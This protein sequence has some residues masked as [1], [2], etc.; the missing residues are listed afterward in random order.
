MKHIKTF[1]KIKEPNRYFKYKIGDIVNQTFDTLF[2]NI[3]KIKIIDYRLSETFNHNRYL[4]E[5]LEYKENT[6]WEYEENINLLTEKELED[7]YIKQVA[8]K[9]NI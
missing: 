1:E 5:D 3:F 8:K 2:H 4:L 9:Y 6:Y 7:Y